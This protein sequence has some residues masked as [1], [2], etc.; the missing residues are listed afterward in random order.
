MCCDSCDQII[1]DGIFRS[2]LQYSFASSQ[3]HVDGSDGR[4]HKLTDRLIPR[5]YQPRGGWSVD[6]FIH[7]Q[8]TSVSSSS[9]EAVAAAVSALLDLNEITYTMP[10]LWLNLQIQWLSRAILKYQKVRLEDVLAISTPNY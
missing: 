1:K 2:G 10:Q 3:R 5:P 4:V 6:I 8:R 9:P 7:N